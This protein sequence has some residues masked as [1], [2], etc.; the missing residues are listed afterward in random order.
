[1][2]NLPILT[3]IFL[4]LL[5]AGKAVAQDPHQAPESVIAAENFYYSL[6]KGDTVSAAHELHDQIQWN[7]TDDFPDSHKNSGNRKPPVDESAFA[8][9]SEWNSFRFSGLEFH[10]TDDNILLVTGFYEAQHNKTGKA[11]KS[12]FAHLWWIKNRKLI[13]FQ[14]C[15]DTKEV[16]IAIK[17]TLVNSKD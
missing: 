4:L 11:I 12:K 1:M 17:N 2:K 7:E 5:V 16:E 13:R 6:E 9:Y 14:E 8:N 3:A 10:P 15:S